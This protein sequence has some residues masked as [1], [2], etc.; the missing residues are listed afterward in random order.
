MQ[1]AADERESEPIEVAD[2]LHA[3]PKCDYTSG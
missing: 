2:E 1:M 3:C